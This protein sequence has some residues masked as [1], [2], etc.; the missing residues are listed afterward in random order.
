MKEKSVSI[1]DAEEIKTFVA[2][3]NGKIESDPERENYYKYLAVKEAVISCGFRLKDA[4]KIVLQDTIGLGDTSLGID[5]AMLD[6]IAKNSDAAVI[7]KR[8]EISSGKFDDRDVELYQK[9]EENFK[10]KNMGKWLFWLTNETKG[11]P[12]GDNSDRCRVVDSK[13]QSLRWDLAGHEVVDV[14]DSEQVNEQFLHTALTKLVQ[15]MDSIDNGLISELDGMADDLY[16]E[17]MNLQDRVQEILNSEVKNSANVHKIVNSRWYEFYNQTFMKKFKEYMVE[18]KEKEEK[19]CTD[20][21][22]YIDT[23]LDS[24]RSMVPDVRELM[25]ELQAGGHHGQTSVYEDNLDRL[26]TGFT[27]RFLDIDEE[28]L[29]KMVMDVKEHFVNLFAEDDGGRMKYIRPVD[30]TRPKVEWLSYAVEDIFKSEDYA[31][32]KAAFQILNKFK[33]TVRGFLMNKVRRRVKTMELETGNEKFTN[34]GNAEEQAEEIWRLLD[35]KMKKVCDALRMDFAEIY[36]EP[37][38]IL[39]AVIREFYDRLNFSSIPGKTTA[40]DLWKSLYYDNCTKVWWEEFKDE[41]EKSDMYRAWED[42]ETE[43]KK[44]TRQDFLV[45]S[46]N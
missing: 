40:E 23:I 18:W 6:T 38:E 42:I 43:L 46:G 21:R 20:F 5:D 26:R 24:A 30:E 35:R 15:N 28:I 45:S 27:K 2:Q 11:E 16:R 36:R 8:P 3:H 1:C 22:N 33:L 37:N 34:T 44:Y 39:A 25:Y 32:F 29:D 13:I 10:R 14:S 4:G 7:V 12:Y 9:L 31:E 17:Y 19:E 41:E